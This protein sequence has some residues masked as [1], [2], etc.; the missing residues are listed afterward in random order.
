VYL[1]D[2]GRRLRGDEHD[3]DDDQHDGDVVLVTVAGETVPR[4][5][6]H[7]L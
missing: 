5:L 2:E 3:D 1:S 6:T 4:H 7:H